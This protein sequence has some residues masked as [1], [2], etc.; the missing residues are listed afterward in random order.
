MD[1]NL[2]DIDIMKIIPNI[3]NKLCNDHRIRAQN[4]QDTSFD[5][6]EFRQ[7]YVKALTPEMFRNIIERISNMNK[8]IDIDGNKMKLTLH[9][10]NN[11]KTYNP[12]F[13]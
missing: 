10:I 4:D 9:G 12:F 8:E 2:S 6:E 7:N 3:M 5:I 11:C 1:N 13:I